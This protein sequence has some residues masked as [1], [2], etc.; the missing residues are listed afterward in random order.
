MVNTTKDG[1]TG[2]RRLGPQITERQLKEA[3]IQSI[4]DTNVETNIW[5]P[6]QGQRLAAGAI[7]A[8]DRAEIAR[9]EQ[10]V[11]NI[12][13]TLVETMQSGDTWSNDKRIGAADKRAAMSVAET[14]LDQMLENDMITPAQAV[15]YQKDLNNWIDNYA[16]EYK[17]TTEKAEKETQLKI[18]SDLI[19]KMPGK[20]VTYADIASSGLSASKQKLWNEYLADSYT[21]PAPRENT[22][23][24][25][26]E[27]VGAVIDVALLRM[28]PQDAIDT[29]LEERYVD[30]SI[31]DDQL[32]WAVDKIENPY[33]K[34]MVPDIR[35]T[36]NDNIS[37]HNRTWSKDAARNNE[38]N[39]ALLAWVDDQLAQDKKP[40]RSE[41]HGISSQYRIDAMDIPRLL[42]FGQ[43]VTRGDRDYEVV[44]FTD[45]GDVEMEPIEEPI[46][47][48]TFLT[49]PG[50]TNN[51]ALRND[52]ITYKQ[53]GWLGPQVAKNN[54]GWDFVATEYSV[55]SNAVKV[56][57]ERID[58]PTLVPTLTDKE[59]KQMMEDIIPNKKRIPE[60]IM[61]KAIDHAN[62][63]LRKGESVFWEPIE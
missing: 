63:Q 5:S 14:A 31:T 8:L 18:E 13:P 50:R 60:P 53:R 41:M 29:L 57:G 46:K 38:V 54:N 9:V 12:K 30:H 55:Q 27:T 61:R 43:I 15:D 52:G 39:E 11:E 58:F 62:K 20:G 24:G 33:P 49:S 40:T 23:S 26:K 51:Y 44:G 35:A 59:V 42:D 48:S 25:L 19:A 3:R 37:E 16:Q 17:A 4:I 6:Q 10:A 22:T 21:N 36:L 47:T 7:D 28:S 56:N 1:T 2:L 45:D 34:H 32:R